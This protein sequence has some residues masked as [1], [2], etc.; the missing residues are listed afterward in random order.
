MGLVRQVQPDEVVLLEPCQQSRP[1]D[2]Q[3][4]DRGDYPVGRGEKFPSQRKIIARDAR[5]TPSAACPWR[6]LQRAGGT[7]KS[8]CPYTVTNL[9][10]IIL[11]RI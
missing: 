6:T 11:P 9:H 5:R 3:A 1:I 7:F 4:E 10:N 2:H 8:R